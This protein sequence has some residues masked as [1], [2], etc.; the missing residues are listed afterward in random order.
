MVSEI[1]AYHGKG[2]HTTTYAR[3]FAADA[4]TRIIDTPGIKEF[5]LETIEP[6]RVGHYFKDFED[7]IPLCR[8]NNCLHLEEPDCGVHQAIA[9]GQISEQRFTSYLRILEEMMSNDRK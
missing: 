7:F 6:W 3:M 2:T 4:N 8:F 5:G 1:S 9:S